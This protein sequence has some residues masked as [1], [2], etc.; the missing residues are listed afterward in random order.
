MAAYRRG[1]VAESNFKGDGT[2]LGGILAYG[3]G[4]KLVYRH[5]EADFGVLPPLEEV[6]E[7]ARKAANA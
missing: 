1:K 4:G 6:V 2:T 3:K 7:A 5:A